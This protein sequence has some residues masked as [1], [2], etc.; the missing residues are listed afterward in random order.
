MN[1]D[2]YLTKTRCEVSNKNLNN[3]LSEKQTDESLEKSMKESIIEKEEKEEQV[4]PT[5]L[6]LKFPLK[7]ILSGCDF[8]IVFNNQQFTISIPPSTLENTMIQV[9]EKLTIIVQYQEDDVYKRIDNDLHAY[10]SFNR[11]YEN[12]ETQPTYIYG[13]PLPFK[14]QLIENETYYFDGYGFHDYTTQK[15][16]SYI[17]HVAFSD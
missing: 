16:G 1:S 12:L 7:F 9:N 11:E 10:F 2:K 3:N 4:E 6:P 17:I 8:P 14:I 13:N 5:L 15:T